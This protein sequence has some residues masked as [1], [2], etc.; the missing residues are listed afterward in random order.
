MT[1]PNF[2]VIGAAKSG[3]DALCSFLA[4]HPQVYMSDLKEPNF[5]V[6]EGRPE[7]PYLG[8]GDREVLT[9][10]DMWVSSLDRYQALFAGVTTEQAVGEGSTWYLYDERAPGRIRRHLPDVRLVAIL[11]NPVDR[12]YSAFTMMLRDGR[13]TTSSF[14]A[15]LAAED[16]RVRSGWE[17]IWHYRRMGLYHEQ[18]RRYHDT[19]DPS[20]LRV[21]LHD[22]FSARPGEVVRD[23]YRFLGVDDGFQ[24]DTSERLNV[25]VVSG[26]LT[27]QRLVD[28]RNPL[29]AAGRAL[30]P[31]GLRQRIKEKLV[32]STLSRPAPLAPELRRQLA[33]TFR[34]DVLRLQELLGRDLSRWLS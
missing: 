7:I 9:R 32:Y 2:L 18:L 17:L 16:E 13:E 10:W 14:A 6:A 23:L 28:G 5:F 3:T 34:P 31:A 24:P 8:P 26:N 27:Y 19:F 15:A 30:L 1:M 12:A 11:R 21:V 22:D 4:Q 25:S 20:Q 33:D 29:K